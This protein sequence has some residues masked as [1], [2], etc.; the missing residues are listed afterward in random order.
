[1]LKIGEQIIFIVKI[2]IKMIKI[3]QII[4][5]ETRKYLME[6]AETFKNPN[7]ANKMKIYA[8]DLQNDLDKVMNDGKQ[9]LWKKYSFILKNI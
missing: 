4:K 5:E 6:Y 2:Y 1:M 8:E 9:H 7:I 3:S